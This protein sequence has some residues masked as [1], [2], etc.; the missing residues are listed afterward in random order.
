MHKTIKMDVTAVVTTSVVEDIAGSVKND[1]VIPQ[2]IQAYK[3][4]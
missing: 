1:S 2:P 4:N 3:G